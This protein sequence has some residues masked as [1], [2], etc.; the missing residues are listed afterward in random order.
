MS[1]L[2]VANKNVFFYYVLFII[3][4]KH[5]ENEKKLL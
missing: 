4:L 2:K 5:L 3:T 1:N